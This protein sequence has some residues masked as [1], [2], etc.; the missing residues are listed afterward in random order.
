M[1]N[2]SLSAALVLCLSLFIGACP[3]EDDPVTPTAD[4]TA[5]VQTDGGGDGGTPDGTS[6]DGT[7]DATPDDGPG[8]DADATPTD[9]SCADYCAL[10]T[11]NCTGDNAQYTDETACLTYCETGASLP[12]GTLADTGGNTVGC[13]MYHAQAA[14]DLND[15]VT[16]CPHAGP[17]GGNICGTWCENYCHLEDV[18]C[19]ANNDIFG[20]D[21][22]C[23]AACALYDPN[24]AAGDADG[25]TVQCRIYHLGVA[26]LDSPDS[27]DLHCPHGAEDGGGVCVDAAPT[28]ESYCTTVTANCTGD[29][30]QYADYDD[31]LAY[32]STE[33]QLPVGESG[34]VDGNSIGCREY[35]AEFAASSNDPD[36]HC[37]HAGPSGGG[38]C[39]TW[40]DNYCHLAD[41]NCTGGDALTFTTDCATDCADFTAT[42][43]PGATSGDTVQCRIYHL[44]VAGDDAQG[45]AAVHCPHGAVA[46]TDQCVDVTPTDPSCADYCTA[47]TA[48]CTDDNAQYADY[49]DCLAYCSTEAQLPLGTLADTDVNTVG[50]RQYHVQAAIDQ[51]DPALHCPHAGPSGGGLCGSWCDNY[52]HL[53]DTNCTGGDALSFTTDCATDCAAFA[54]T[55]DPGATSGDTVQCRIYHLGVAGDDAQGGASVH[56]P[57]GGPTPTAQCVDVTPTD[58]SCADYCTAITATCT[59][60]NAQ[61]ADYDDCLAYCTTEAAL[62][63]GTL[64]DTNVNSV[65]CRQY[66]VQAAIDSSNPDLHCPHAGPSGGNFC[67]SWCDNYCHLANTNCTGGDALSFTTDCATDCAA[68]TDTGDPGDTSGDTVQ[69]RIYHLGVAGDDAQGGAA[70]HCPHGGPTPTAQCVDATPTE[71]SCD[72]YCTAITATCTGNNAQYADYDD[73]LAYCTIEAQLPLGTLA[74]TNVNTVGCRQYHV[75]AAVTSSN[76][77]LHCPH[78][79]PSGGNF[80]GSWCDNYCHLANTNCTGGDALSF[81]TD[82]AT[83]C[84]AFTDTGDPGDTSGDTVQCRIYHLG[85]A[86]DD[87]QGGAAVHCPHGGPTP[88]AQ[89]VDVTPTGPTCENYCSTYFTNCG[90]EEN[91]QYTNEADCLAFCAASG[92]PTGTDPLTETGGNTVACR[93]YHATA[94]AD[95]AALHCPHAG[96]DGGTLC[97]SLCE[98]YCDLLENICPTQFGGDYFDSADCVTSCGNDFA[99]DA[100]FG[101]GSGN[102]VQCRFYHA[103]VAAA[104]AAGDNSVHCGHAGYLGDGICED[105]PG[106]VIINE[107]NYNTDATNDAGEFVELYNAGDVEIPSDGLAGAFLVFV[108]GNGGEFYYTL[109]LNG[110]SGPI[111]PGGYAVIGD[112]TALALVPNGVA[113]KELPGQSGGRIQNGPDAVAVVVGDPEADGAIVFDTLTYQ[114]SLGLTGPVN[115]STGNPVD[116]W[117]DEDFTNLDDPNTAG[118]SLSRCSDAND[119]GNNGAD[120]A[121]VPSTPGAANDCSGQGGTGGTGPTFD[122]DIQPI[123]QNNCSP[124]HTGAGSG[125]GNWT[126]YADTQ[127]PSYYCG[128]Q[129][130]GECTAT[131]IEDLSMPLGNPGGVPSADLELIKLWIANGMPEN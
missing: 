20:D 123:F 47:I 8:G 37:P 51:N 25:D 92:I 101:V 29:N 54:A 30:A 119:T 33:A 66:H 129:T 16:H 19:T 102:S 7:P 104:D 109:E 67:G 72:A 65:G 57:H 40:C 124:C 24:G 118:E 105:A 4:V 21:A 76:P 38:V 100:N 95:N 88:T 121:L 15:P 3:E 62:P 87:G 90:A 64:A 110:L 75:D 99:A 114:D 55:G 1:A 56:C 39:G 17:S 80:C 86:G 71:P 5:D 120:F 58:P 127:K 9:P 28:C 26:G 79:G 131:R 10:V 44:G 2:R 96:K 125:G 126:T 111:P 122:A 128:G 113:T 52:C 6:D 91:N 84:A 112:T 35:H 116:W 103:T 68:F 78:A 106:F 49:D 32:C 69:C 97:G 93:I 82:C 83:D 27:N 11:A 108:N 63:L 77:D 42:G 50:C 31:C 18:N 59:G 60:D 43:D 107:V 36:T 12:I 41:T 130:K 46:P 22:A 23:Q 98:N 74:D 34:A 94:A 61:Y 14:V 53:S 45:G 13:R 73:C 115:N 48:T 70:V 117:L 85:V 89:C 81:T